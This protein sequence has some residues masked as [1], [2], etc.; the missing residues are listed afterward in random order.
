MLR[1]SETIEVE[2][3]ADI[4]DRNAQH[5]RRNA[6]RVG[7]ATRHWSAHYPATKWLISKSKQNDP[8][9]LMDFLKLHQSV[10]VSAIGVPHKKDW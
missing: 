1:S 7:S 5:K 9:Q 2:E 3:A 8:E 10:E 4:C 6:R